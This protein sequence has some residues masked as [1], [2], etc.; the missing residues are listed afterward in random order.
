VFLAYS[1]CVSIHQAETYQD[2]SE[3][4][5]RQ[6]QVEVNDETDKGEIGHPG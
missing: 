1:L 6:E 2:I 5:G 3:A 4:S